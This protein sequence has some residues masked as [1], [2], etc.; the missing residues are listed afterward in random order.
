MGFLSPLSILSSF[1]SLLDGRIPPNCLL[2]KT[3][4]RRPELKSHNFNPQVEKFRNKNSAKKQLCNSR[5]SL[6]RAIISL[7][8]VSMQP[9]VFERKSFQKG[10]D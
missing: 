3:I 9:V 2:S 5:F 10:R 8:M 7:L 4:P 1:D 6:M